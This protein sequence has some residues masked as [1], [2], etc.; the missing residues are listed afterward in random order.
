MRQAGEGPDADLPEEELPNELRH[1]P[2]EG[3]LQFPPGFEPAEK[4]ARWYGEEY[5]PSF[6]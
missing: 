3:E 5:I 4:T 2:V 1:A 6:K